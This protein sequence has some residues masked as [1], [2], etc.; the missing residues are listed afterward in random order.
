MNETIYPF[1][2][3]CFSSCLFSVLN[4]LFQILPSTPNQ[5]YNINLIP[6]FFITIGKSLI[7]NLNY[8]IIIKASEKFCKKKNLYLYTEVV[9]PYIIL[10]HIYSALICTTQGSINNTFFSYYPIITKL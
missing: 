3:S 7:K 8:Y 5:V 4:D 6:L 2:L 9:K 10:T 1:Y